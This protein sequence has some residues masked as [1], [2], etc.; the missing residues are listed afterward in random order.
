MKCNVTYFEKVKRL[1]DKLIY[2]MSEIECE[3]DEGERAIQ[4]RYCVLDPTSVEFVSSSVGHLCSIQPN[5]S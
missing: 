2:C 3:K 1:A 5:I 4:V